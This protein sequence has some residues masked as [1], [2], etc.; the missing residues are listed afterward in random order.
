MFIAV[1]MVELVSGMLRHTSNQFPTL[2]L[3]LKGREKYKSIRTVH[4]AAATLLGEWPTDDGDCYFEAIMTCLDALYK[5]TPPALV[6][7]ALIR[8]ADEENIGHISLVCTA[9]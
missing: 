3:I 7:A 6:R 8:A 2:R 5:A 4:E 9:N 1:L